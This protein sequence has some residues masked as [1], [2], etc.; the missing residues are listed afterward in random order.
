MLR[1]FQFSPSDW[2]MGGSVQ[3]RVSRNPLCHSLFRPVS[4]VKQGSDSELS[5]VPASKEI[6]KTV[7]VPSLLYLLFWCRL[8]IAAISQM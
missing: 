7:F 3:G 5:Q 8:F 4:K 1:G 6:L 2:V